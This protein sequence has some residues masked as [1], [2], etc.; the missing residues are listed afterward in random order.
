[1]FKKLGKCVLAGIL[2]ACTVMTAAPAMTSVVRAADDAVVIDD[3]EFTYS[4]GKNANDGGWDSAAGADAA[5]SEHWSNTVGAWAEIDFNGTGLEIYG[6]KASNHRMFSVQ[7]DGGEAVE[8][9]AYAAASTDNNALLYSTEAAGIELKAGS[10]TARVTILDKANASASNVLGMN[11]AY[12]KVYGGEIPEE[13]EFPGYTDVDDSVVTT[14]GEAFKVQYEPS[15]RWHAESGYPNLFFDGTDH[16]SD[17]DADT[18]YYTMTFTGTG[19]EIWAS[20][21][22]AHANFDVFIDDVNVGS[23][24]AK[25]ESGSAV[26]QQK[27]FETTELENTEHTLKVVKQSGDAAALQLDKIRVYHDELA[28]ESITLDQ[29]EALLIPGGTVQLTAALTPWNASD[30]LVWESSDPEMVSV[31]DG[32]L[33]ASEDITEKTTVTVT[34]RSAVDESAA[35]S[36]EITVDPALAVMN[37]YVGDEKLLDMGE[38]YDSLKGGS[39]S[40]FSGTAWK[41]DE[42]NSKIV[43]AANKDVHNVQVTASDLKTED[44]KTLS[45][46]NVDIK[47]LKEVTAKEGRNAAGERKQYP[48]IIYKGGAK[49]IEAN[50]VQFA[51]V[52]IAVPE[53]TAA[54]TYTGTISVTADELDQAFELTYT[55]EVINLV[56]PTAQDVGYEVQIWQHPFSVA[57]YYLGLGDE[58][59]P[60]GG[61]CNESADD[62]YFTE[63]HFALM[64][65]SMQEYKELGGRDVVANIVEE[66]WN[67]QSFYGDPS[68]VQWTKKSDGTW[69]FDYDWYDKW[70]NFQIEMGILDPANGEG[71]IKCYSIVPWNN[72][73]AYYDEASGM[74]KKEVFTPGSDKFTEIWTIFLEDFMKHS[75][76]MG[77]FDITY[78]SMDERGLDLLKPAVSVIES[79]TNEEGESF[80]ISSAM[81]AESLHEREFLKRVDDISIN[82]DNAGDVELMN[83]V[84]AE[85]REL[86]LK[87][88]YYTCTGNYPGNF[89]ISDPGDNYWTAWYSLTLG[90]DGFMRWA[91]DNYLYDMFGDATYRYWEP[92]DGWFI[93]P[94]ERGT[95]DTAESTVYSTPR[96]EMF[97]QGVRDACKAKYLLASD[98]VTEEQ[99]EAYSAVV[100][101]LQRPSKT[102]YA[103]AAVPSNETQRML[104]HS[105][106]ERALTATNDLAREI[107]EAE[108]PSG[109]Q[110]VSKKT[111]EYFLNKAQAYVEGGA[112][113]SCVES[114]QKLF[115][116]AIAEGKAVM[117]DEDATRDEVMD[118]SLK[119]LKAIH[120]LDMKAANKTDLEMAAEL[121][122]MI[123][124]SK[125]VEAGQKEFKDAL[126][127]A[128]EVLADGDAMQ[129]EVDAAW[130]E[131]AAA[132]ENLRLKADKEILEGLLDE[133][134]GLDLSQYT[135]ESAAAFRAALASAQ[136]VY[137]DE[138]LSVMDQQKVDDAVAALKDAKDGLTAK[139]DDSDDGEGSGQKPD[140]DKPGTGTSGSDSSQ[141]DNGSGSGNQAA[142]SSTPKTGDST[143]IL[144]VLAVIAMAA[145]VAGI[146]VRK[147]F[148]A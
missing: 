116:E 76:E 1:M 143:P 122:D 104:A 94:V 89:M 50:D 134:A 67:H 45:K 98:Q 77:W 60:G 108:T 133:L 43:V 81:N 31:E 53:D 13:P 6:K 100:E 59:S 79:V 40:T 78:I 84:A 117:A 102:T 12:V 66:A 83:E 55:V 10:H 114:V 39:G 9:D 88:T 32:L 69:E 2:S 127:A 61:I 63:E 29:T 34:V 25:L 68:M 92:G 82:L 7:I 144:V 27:L 52:Q 65:D 14:S 106:T 64:E 17:K 48:D 74:T 70:I 140:T 51:W 119:L 47:W 80:K 19:I 58:I 22:P 28:P 23:G 41:A 136:A 46:D 35:A 87:T 128:K 15:G 109:D 20:K 57:N 118:A 16:Y 73:I 110:T 132:M 137:A 129:D 24:E 120:A 18:D 95:E 101:N 85:R 96:Y 30:E 135:E 5:A 44:G 115:E 49:D 131:L 121:A 103:G 72:Q 21:N 62:F 123:D 145:A 139:A 148:R 54:G 4:E 42:L 86:G 125:Y 130:D 75:E 38:D 90:T 26:H 111:L 91:W 147:R 11:L 146:V 8:C 33:T 126:A 93:Y 3:T 99:K 113:D 71:Q 97:K 142:G 141:T 37:A 56:Q 124:L 107:A 138:T 112:V 105:E 36:A